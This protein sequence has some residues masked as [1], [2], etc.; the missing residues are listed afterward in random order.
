MSQSASWAM[1]ILRPRVKSVAVNNLMG[2]IYQSIM[3]WAWEE[4]AG[5]CVKEIKEE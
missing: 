4:N 5:P 2:H 1:R 3:D